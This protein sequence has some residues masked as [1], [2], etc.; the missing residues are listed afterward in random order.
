MHFTVYGKHPGSSNSVEYSLSASRQ[1]HAA[2]TQAATDS[3]FLSAMQ[4]LLLTDL[5]GGAILS[6][7]NCRLGRAKLFPFKAATQTL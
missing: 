2:A 6:Y 7:P 5:S 3:L 1:T 4:Y